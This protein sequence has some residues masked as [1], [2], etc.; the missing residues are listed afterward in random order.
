MKI[1]TVDECNSK[2]YAKGLCTKHYQRMINSGSTQDPLKPCECKIDGCKTKVKSKGFCIKHYTRFI[3]FGCADSVS[4][5][6]GNDKLRLESSCKVNESGC[7][8]WVKH[9]KN[10]YG[11][12]VLQGKH[13]QAHRASWKVFIGE[14][15]DGMQ[16][17]H[18][19]HNR[20]CINPDH[21]Y[22]GTQKQNMADMYNS[23]RDNHPI[24]SKCG[25][26]KLDEDSVSL[27][28][29]MINSG[30][31][32][33]EIADTFKVSRACIQFIRIGR[34]WNHVK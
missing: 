31:K 10:G 1:C 26:S 21:L 20:S 14:I 9:K 18:R 13:E 24:G 27:I 2:H 4:V 12:T 8:E 32:N 29:I 22:V 16:I 33:Q 23:G 3:R 28:K 30:I 5:I 15:P 7:W 19:C 17:N 6:I 11:I 34:T 25:N